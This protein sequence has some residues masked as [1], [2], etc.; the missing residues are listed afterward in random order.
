MM[1]AAMMKAIPTNKKEIYSRGI[2]TVLKE[3]VGNLLTMR[4]PINGI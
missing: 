1:M 3:K 2:L 4:S